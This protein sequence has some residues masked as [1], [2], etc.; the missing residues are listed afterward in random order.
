MRYTSPRLFAQLYHTWSIT[1]DTYAMNQRT[2]NYRSFID[3]GFSEEEARQRSFTEAWAGVSPTA[4]VALDRGSVFKDNSRRWNAEVQYNND[5]NIDGF[6]LIAGVQWQQDI[7]DSKGTY[8]LDADDAITINQVG[9]YAQLEQKFGDSGFKAVL[10]ARADN[11]D[12]YGFNFV[13]KA[14]V[15]YTMDNGGTFRFTYGQGIAAPTILNLEANIFGGLLL[16]NG[17]G[18][19]LSDGSTIEELQVETIQTFEVGYKGQIG[20][21]FYLD[22]NGYYNISKDFLSPAINI[23]RP[24]DGVFVTERDE[25]SLEQLQP[26]FATA[27][28]SPLVL[29]YTNFGSVDTYGVDVGLNYYFNDKF[30]L[31][32]NYSYF[33]FNLDKADLS[34]DGN[35][36][37]QVLNTDLPINS[38]EHKASLA[39]NVNTGKIFGSLFLRWVDEYDFFSGINVAAETQ[40]T[41]GDGVNDVMED[42]VVGRTWNYGPLGGF[43]N[44]D[45]S[46]GYRF[47]DMFTLSGQVSNIF[48][49]E[50]REF[51][52]SPSIGRLYSVEFKVNLPAFGGR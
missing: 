20:E 43:V 49:S 37:G 25:Q 39:F 48:D 24:T 52:G 34:N 19:T 47:N 29:T 44:V 23:A 30:N 38:P 17:A 26:G 8:L 1:E 51:V 18:F 6:N 2:Q 16:G 40:D 9:G 27:A 36:D 13:P 21:R 12:L 45:L 35:G 7:A 46:V 50:V 3:A 4:G 41:N 15:L 42:A 31:V 22:V 14:A 33:G 10:A 28:G 5:F 11:H 32:L